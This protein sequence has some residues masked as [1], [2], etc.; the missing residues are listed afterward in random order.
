MQTKTNRISAREFNKLFLAILDET[1]SYL[2]ENAKQT[3]YYH[4][5]HKFGIRRSEIPCRVEDFS[6]A[7]DKIFGLANKSIEVVLVQKLHEKVGCEFRA[8]SIGDFT[9]PK[10][11]NMVRKKVVAAETKPETIE[12]WMTNPEATLNA[13]KVEQY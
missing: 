7:M 3:I 5:E 8:A 13:A 9:F 1:F 6:S 11:V 12:T 4:L 10:Y 2:G